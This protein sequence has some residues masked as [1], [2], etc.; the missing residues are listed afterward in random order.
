LDAFLLSP[1][2]LD[3]INVECKDF[4][5]LAIGGLTRDA[6]GPM[7]PVAKQRKVINVIEVRAHNKQG[8]DMGTV[9]VPGS[10]DDVRAYCVINSAPSFVDGFSIEGIGIVKVVRTVDGHA[11]GFRRLL[12]GE[13]VTGGP[14]I[15]A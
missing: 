14:E 11:I 3:I 12:N 1:T 8:A 10:V 6:H 5:V 13:F 2:P 15:I 4:H 7:M 9:N